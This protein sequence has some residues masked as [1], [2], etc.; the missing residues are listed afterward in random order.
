ME[1]KI[2]A[3]C[4]IFFLTSNLHYIVNYETALK[5]FLITY[6]IA[7]QEDKLKFIITFL[8]KEK[9]TIKMIKFV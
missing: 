8:T 6:L 1:N 3:R 2:N 7:L 5:V 9:R 4:S